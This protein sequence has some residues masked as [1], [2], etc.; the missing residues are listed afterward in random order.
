MLALEIGSR[1]N[2]SAAVSTVMELTEPHQICG[3]LDPCAQFLSVGNTRILVLQEC[4]IHPVLERPFDVG[5]VQLQGE[6]ESAVGE[7]APAFPH[8]A[9]VDLGIVFRGLVKVVE[10]LVVRIP[11]TTSVFGEVDPIMIRVGLDVGCHNV[12]AG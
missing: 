1:G 10:V 12:V 8:A 7:I 4:Q 9:L 5:V 6:V 11:F 3:A 2:M